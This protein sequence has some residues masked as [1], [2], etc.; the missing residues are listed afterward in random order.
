MKILIIGHDKV[1]QA[2]I[3]SILTSHDSSHELIILNDI[4][5]GKPLLAKSDV[6]LLVLNL[7]VSNIEESKA[8]FKSVAKAIMLT[9]VLLILPEV[10]VAEH[11]EFGTV[12]SFFKSA[13]CMPKPLSVIKLSSKM[14]DLL[15]GEN[16]K[17]EP[18][19]LF[20]PVKIDLFKPIEVLPCDIFVKISD[21]KFVKIVKRG[22]VGPI[23][24]TIERYQGKGIEFLYVEKSAYGPLSQLLLQDLFAAE[25]PPV[26]E[27]GIMITEAVMSVT[28]DLGASEVVIEAVQESYTEVIKSLEKEKVSSLLASLSRDENIFVENH[29]YLTSVFAVMLSR[30]MTWSSEKIQYNLCM[31]AL[32]HDSILADHHLGHHDRDDLETIKNLPAK[33]RDIVL[34]HP[35]VLADKLSKTTKLPS[36]VISLISKHHEGSGKDS[37]PAIDNASAMQPVNCLFNVAHQFSIELYK[38]GFNNKK[39]PQAFANLRAMY[40]SSNMKVYIDLLE[41]NVTF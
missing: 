11:P 9:R 39:L 18:E 22:Q 14:M 29:S 7:D 23:T 26:V 2:K 10:S 41:D 31:A 12:R 3:E 19:V 33:T 37:Y 40:R 38:I 34:N 27:R 6:D 36:D 5:D 25:A 8:L 20:L 16:Q 35:R 1:T 4:K 13:E 28:K 32:L 24:D 15:T 17:D 30:H 21:V